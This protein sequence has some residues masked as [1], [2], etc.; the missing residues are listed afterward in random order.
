MPASASV[1]VGLTVMP[2]LARAGSPS[3]VITDHV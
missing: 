1:R 2:L 3:G